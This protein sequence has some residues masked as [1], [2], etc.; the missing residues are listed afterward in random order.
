MPDHPHE[1][2]GEPPEREGP[3]FEVW[4]HL[5]SGLDMARRDMAS[6]LAPDSM[7]FYEGLAK[8][9]V[10]TNLRLLLTSDDSWLADQLKRQFPGMKAGVEPNLVHAILKVLKSKKDPWLRHAVELEV[11][12][13]GIE[14]A[15]GA[16]NRFMSLMPIF[17][18]RSIPE[19]AQPYIR[20]VV[21]TF[22]FGF[23]AACMALCRST[24]EQ[25]AKTLL[26]E[27]SAYTEGQLRR[28]QP[29]AATLL[30]K[31]KQGG[32]V[33]RSY[34]AAKRVVN[35]GN[36]VM[37]GHMYDQKILHQEALDSLADLVVVLQEV[38][39]T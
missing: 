33:S 31:L 19:R 36:T 27:R 11:A 1:Q 25:V 18:E 34:D 12:Q 35:R 7:R 3:D 21:T 17:A 4:N 37:H 26:I 16:L 39:A 38:L 23:D 28:E 14:R 2:E 5:W 15:D 20:E 9:V 30:E 13:V 6:K 29:T 8:T 24:F 22:L 32:G 10:G